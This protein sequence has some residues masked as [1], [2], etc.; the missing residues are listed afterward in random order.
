MEYKTESDQKFDQIF[1]AIEEREITPKQGIFF[2][3]QIF[4][5]HKLLSDIFRSARSSI[6]IIDNYLDDSILA[7]LSKQDKNVVVK[8]F[9]GKINPQLKLDVKKYNEQYPCVELIKLTKA[10]DRFIIIDEKQVYHLGASLKDLGKKWFAFTK[11]DNNGRLLIDHLK[12][13]MP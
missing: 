7:L 11:M 8:I 3:G 5:A 1:N 2:D 12:R 4:D 6:Y 13:L 10:H 9:S